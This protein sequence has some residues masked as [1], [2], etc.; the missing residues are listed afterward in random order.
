M[1]PTPGV[2]KVLVHVWHVRCSRSP[3]TRVAQVAAAW[4][5]DHVWQVRRPLHALAAME[6]VSVALRPFSRL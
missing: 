2:V 1:R 5:E 3:S 4:G 6:D